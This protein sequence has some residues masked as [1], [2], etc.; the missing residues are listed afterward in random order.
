MM[1]HGK[2]KC[3][4]YKL[5]RI[6]VNIHIRLVVV[7]NYLLG[8]SGE[9]LSHS[10]VPPHTNNRTSEIIMTQPST[11]P[12]KVVVIILF[13]S[14]MLATV[15]EAVVLFVSLIIVGGSKSSD[16]IEAHLIS[17]VIIVPV[18]CIYLADTQQS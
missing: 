9:V 16:L 14:L 15:A 8:A 10:R 17:V 6:F 4:Q 12:T 18:G 7:L 1:M 13:E 5:H 3:Y 11:V 2:L